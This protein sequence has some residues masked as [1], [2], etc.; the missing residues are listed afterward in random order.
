M[1]FKINISNKGKTLKIETENEELIGKKIGDTISGEEHSSELEGYELE[2]TGTSDIA[3]F[4][5]KKDLEGS[6]LRKV[7]LTKGFGM[8]KTRPKGLRKKKTLAGNTIGKNTIQINTKVKKEGKKKFAELLPQKKEEEKSEK[9][10]EEKKPSAEPEE[11][12]KTAEKKGAEE[13]HSES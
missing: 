7:L 10:E 2:I 6:G 1:V 4:P 9:K 8:K 11:K 12:G 5:G 13:T 3:G